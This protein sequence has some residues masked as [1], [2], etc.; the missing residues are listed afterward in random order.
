MREKA[1]LREFTLYKPIT[2]AVNGLAIGLGTE[3]LQ[4][5]DLRIA[6]EHAA[7]AVN[8]VTRG[9]MPGGGSAVRVARPIPLCKAMEIVL[10]GDR[11]SAQEA[12]RPR[13]DEDGFESIKELE[14]A[15][16]SAAGRSACAF[17][18]WWDASAVQ[19][20][21]ADRAYPPKAL[22]SGIEVIGDNRQLSVAPSVHT[23]GRSYQWGERRCAV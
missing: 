10:V 11:I 2:A 19:V 17:R 15:L 5:T 12:W 4:A 8:E 16:W 1:S 7:F 9:F 23:S 22:G 20:P 14:K 13:P 3:L 18:R 6:I 21:G